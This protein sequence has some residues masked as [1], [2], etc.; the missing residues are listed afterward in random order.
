LF[1]APLKED[2]KAAK[3]HK[4]RHQPLA[5]AAQIAQRKLNLLKAQQKRFLAVQGLRAAL[6]G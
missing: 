3:M 5:I 6:P 2:K 4:M 1:Q